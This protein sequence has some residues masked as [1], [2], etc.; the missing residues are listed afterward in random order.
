[1]TTHKT[2]H[3]SNKYM[4]KHTVCMYMYT[5]I[6]HRYNVHMTYCGTAPDYGTGTCT[7]FS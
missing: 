7:L 2:L 6:Q 4:Y 1:M 5:N 3:T